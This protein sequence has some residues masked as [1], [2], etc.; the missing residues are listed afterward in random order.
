MKTYEVV[1]G[2][3]IW[4]AYV[5]GYAVVSKEADQKAVGLLWQVRSTRPQRS[6]S[7]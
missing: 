2:I 5:D 3:F 7:S 4:G 1:D 6:L